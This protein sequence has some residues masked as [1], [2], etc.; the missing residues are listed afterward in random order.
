MIKYKELSEISH[1][2][3]VD[4]SEKIMKWVE[5]NNIEKYK[6]IGYHV[7]GEA[8]HVSKYVLIEY[9]EPQSKND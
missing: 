2:Y 6:V 9:E 3:M 1:A 5:E 8:P 7:N 4:M